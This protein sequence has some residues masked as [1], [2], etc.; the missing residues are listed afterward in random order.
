MV[1]ASTDSLD[2]SREMA[3]GK[4]MTHP[5][6]PEIGIEDFMKIDLRVVRIIRA[7]EVAKADKLLRLTV[8]LGGDTREVFAGIKSAYQPSD[9]EGRLAIL[10]ANLAPRKMRFGTSQGMILAAA[11]DEGIFL[12]GTDSGAAPGMQVK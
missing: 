10:V 6:L 11:G 5:I 9:L 8:D 12:L 7:T 1:T 3:R 4:R 2:D